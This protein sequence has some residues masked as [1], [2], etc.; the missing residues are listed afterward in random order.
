MK[1]RPLDK[2]GSSGEK[3]IW[4]IA[5]ALVAFLILGFYALVMKPTS[6]Q[7]LTNQTA[8]TGSPSN[9]Y[10]NP[11]ATYATVDNFSTT[12][13]GGTAYY[14]RDGEQAT[15]TA[16]TNVNPGVE[17]TYWVSNSTYYV[18]PKV[19][20]AG[21]LN[22]NVV[23][24]IAFANGSATVSLYDTTNRQNF[25]VTSYNTSVAA[26]GVANI[27]VSYQGT[28][29]QSF[30]PFGG[31]FVVE[32]NQSFN[33]NG[34]VSCSGANIQANTGDS[35]YTIT[36]NPSSTDMNYVVYKVLPTIDD[37]KDVTVKRINC[38]FQNGASDAA[39]IVKFSFFPAN[40]YLTNDGTIK[41]DVEKVANGATTRTGLGSITASG[42]FA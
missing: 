6:Q 38:Q 27:E 42:V 15:T 30:M 41:L 12:V 25:G 7:Q 3:A 26:N 39:G 33:V 34:G 37:G 32:K 10:V 14:A 35:A 4:T 16:I 31:L 17:Y 24:K 9:V 28:A 18:Q 1:I 19:F 23:N 22:N 20:T 40:Y 2:K 21:N 8:G 13:V 29:K 11:V 36:Y 5:I